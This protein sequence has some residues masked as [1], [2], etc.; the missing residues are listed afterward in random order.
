MELISKILFDRK[1]H[2]S[3]KSSCFVSTVALTSVSD[4]MLNEHSAGQG[5]D[6]FSD[7]LIVLCEDSI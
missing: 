7:C 3:L 1:M 6:C 2:I 4:V 5:S